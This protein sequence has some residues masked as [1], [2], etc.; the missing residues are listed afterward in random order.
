MSFH[1]LKMLLWTFRKEPINK[2]K[3]LPL[4][5]HTFEMVLSQTIKSNTF[6]EKENDI[7]LFKSEWQTYAFAFKWSVTSLYTFFQEQEIWDV[8]VMT[9]L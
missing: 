1:R 9:S 5:P 2:E 8:P 4:L 3:T 6:S 7:D